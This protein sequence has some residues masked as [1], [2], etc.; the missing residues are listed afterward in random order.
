MQHKRWLLYIGA[1]CIAM[2]EYEQLLKRE[3]E[4]RDDMV[5][6]EDFIQVKE[7]LN[8]LQ[9]E[10]EKVKETTAELMETTAS[11]AELCSIIAQALMH[12]RTEVSPRPADPTA[13]STRR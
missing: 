8:K 5:A 9:D 7:K 10:V 4:A 13:S 1:L 11:K 2:I 3:R 12:A 6:K